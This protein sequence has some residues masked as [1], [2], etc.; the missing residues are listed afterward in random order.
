MAK[1]LLKYMLRSAVGEIAL[2][3]EL[4]TVGR[5]PDNDIVIDNQAVSGH[6]ASITVEGDKIVLEDLGSLNGTFVNGQKISKWSCSTAMWFSS[7]C[8]P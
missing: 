4:T 5:K 6:H 1:I 7:A 8:T 2:D 3:K